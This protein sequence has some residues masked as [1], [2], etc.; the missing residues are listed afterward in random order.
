MQNT[1]S[2]GPTL[3]GSVVKYKVD[4]GTSSLPGVGGV[5]GTIEPLGRC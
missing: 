2:V 3:S 4:K 5:K 1:L